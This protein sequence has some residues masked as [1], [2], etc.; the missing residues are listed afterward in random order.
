MTNRP[1]VYIT[2]IGVV[3]PSGLGH[4]RFWDAIVNGKPLIGPITRFDASSYACRIGGQVDDSLLDEFIDARKQRTTSHA[5]RLALVAAELAL[6]DAHLDLTRYAPESIGVCVGTALGGWIDGEQQ[7]AILLE[8][9]AKR[10][11][12]FIVSGAGNHGPG[13][14]IASAVGAEGPQVTFSSG[15]PSSLQALGYAASLIRD[16]TVDVC[17][18]GG[19]ESPLSPTCIAALSRT[20]ELSTTNE[21]P[22]GASRP[23]DTEHNGMVLSEGS[24]ILV[25]ESEKRALERDVQLYAEVVGTNASCDAKGLYGMDLTGYTGART[26]QKLLDASA[27]TPF[28]IDYVCA[29]A[30]GSPS[31]DKKEASVIRSAFGECAARIPVSSIKAILG[32]P[33]GA[34]GAFQVAAMALAIQ[35]TTI[36]PTANLEKPDP[37]CSLMH[38]NRA[39]FTQEINLALATSY[40]YGGLNSFLLLRK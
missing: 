27:A 36:P 12:P 4:A 11:N 23:F 38:V 8:R 19:T 16:G 7:Y 3:A 29:H 24:C 40:G 25:L 22:A 18:A 26:I 33:F 30:N 20:Q 28:D 6:R 14:E 32:H 21:N 15:C 37:E 13:I 34:A 17:L 10:V 5:T 9:G 31:F 39:N 2:G 1:R 35:N